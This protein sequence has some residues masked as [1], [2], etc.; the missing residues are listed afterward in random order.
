MK[1]G[2]FV[3]DSH[4]HAQRFAAGKAM[5]EKLASASAP[6]PGSEEYKK[7][8]EQ[9][10]YEL[11]PYDNSARLLYDMDCYGVDMCI[12]TSA[13]NMTNELNVQIVKNNPGKFVALAYGEKYR[14]HIQRTG[15][16]WSAADAAKELDE[17]LATGNFVGIGEG[18]PQDPTLGAKHRRIDIHSRLDEIAHFMA[19]ARKYKV[20]VRY[21]VGLTMGYTTG[22]CRG[23]GANPETYNPMWVH[24]LAIEW[25]DVP[26]IFEHGGVQAWWWDKWYEEC[27][28]VAAATDNV[29]LETGTWWTELYDKPLR[30]PN[31]GAEKLLWGTDWGSSIPVEWQPGQK[32][33]TYICQRRKT[34][35]VRHQV[36][37]FGWSLKQLGRL[38]I[39]QDDLNLIL[40][41]NAARLYRIKLPHTR[42]FPFVDDIAG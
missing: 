30:D 16:E 32:P 31:I 15:E 21:H 13:F 34:P 25:P 29:Y 20:P 9:L 41:G 33:E 37:M 39:P 35:P 27:L 42:L 38:N 4:V 14:Q 3:I 23:S 22:F 17:L 11:Q 28:N 19:V 7:L 2:R 8:H 5:K 24:D 40:G 10:T 18:F 36:D 6:A 26:I 12:L 1:M